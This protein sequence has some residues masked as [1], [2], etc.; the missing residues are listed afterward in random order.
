MQKPEVTWTIPDA[1]PPIIT[2]V[3]TL[4]TALVPMPL[5]PWIVERSNQLQVPADLIYIP[6]LVSLSSLLGRRVAIQPKRHD[7]WWEPANLWGAIIAEPS[8]AR[9]SACLNLPIRFVTQI[10]DRY[11]NDLHRALEEQSAVDSSVEI[12]LEELA[13]DLRKATKADNHDEAE[14]ILQQIKVAK[15]RSRPPVGKR[16]FVQDTT[17]EQLTT[18]LSQNPAGLLLVRDELT[19]LFAAFSKTGF[20]SLRALLLEAYNG[21]SSMTV[22]RVKNPQPI[23]VP[24]AAISV[25]GGIQPER[26]NHFF[27]S[28]KGAA[29]CRD[30]ML[31]RFQLMVYPTVSTTYEYIDE[32]CDAAIEERVRGLFEFAHSDNLFSD[33]PVSSH[34]DL[35]TLRFDD[36][37]QQQFVDWLTA[38]ERRLRNPPPG[39]STEFISHLGKASRTLVSLTTVFHVIA[40]FEGAENLGTV[41]GKVLLMAIRLRDH[42]EAHA[43]RIYSFCEDQPLRCA[44]TIAAKIRQSQIPEGSTV[45]ELYR[46]GWSGLKTK[47]EVSSGLKKLEALG[48]LRITQ[49]E[50][51]KGGRSSDQILLNPK[52]AVLTDIELGLQELS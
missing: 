17:P 5:R 27:T 43:K 45:R 15:E 30:G 44:H 25:L 10:Q 21:K 2:D 22:D 42:L 29:S 51:V 48:W 37:A 1:L 32:P 33:V 41:S 35:P 20:E 4:D 9:K 46:K 7:P 12:Q 47:E 31:Q 18:L 26:L 49:E 28:G 52:L 19:G 24:A 38:H 14:Q 34:S 50:Q 23:I 3:G 16:L 13:K 8:V 40:A 39:T 11:L 6:T 36:E